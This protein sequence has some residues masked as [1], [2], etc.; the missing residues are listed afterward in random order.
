M[1]FAIPA[2]FDRFWQRS[3]WKKPRTSA[4]SFDRLEDRT[5][6]AGLLITKTIVGTS[7]TF[8]TETQVAVGETVGY[9][10]VLRVPE[11]STSGATLVET[12][13]AGLAMV[14]IDSVSASPT[15]TSSAPGGIFG[16]L[17]NAVISNAGSNP[18]DAGRIATFNLGNLTNSDANSGTEETITLYYTAVVINGGSNDRGDTRSSTATISGPGYS[19]SG[20]SPSVTIV[21]PTLQVEANAT[22]ANASPGDTVTFTVVIS[23]TANSNA[24]AYEV[25]VS[26]V[27]PT[28]VTYVATTL[29]HTSGLAPTT[30]TLAGSTI[31]A[32]FTTFA[33]D[34][35]STLSFQATVNSNVTPNQVITNTATASSTSLP[36]SV[37]VSQSF[38]NTL[39]TERTGNTSNPGGAENDY[40]ATGSAVV[41]ANSPPEVVSIT[42]VGPATT[43]TPTVDFTVTFSEAVT[44]VDLNDF[45]L[46][47][48]RLVGPFVASISG[49]GAVYTITVNTGS[50]GGSVRLDLV[51]DDS[52]LNGVLFRLGGIGAGNGS[53]SSG[54][55]YTINKNSAPT[56]TNKTVVVNEDTAYTLSAADFGFSDPFDTPAHVFQA[57]RITTPP[58]VGTLMNNGVEVTAG[59]FVLVSDLNANLLRFHPAPDGHGNSYA[60]FTFQ[61]QDNGGIVN[62]GL[63]L[64]AGNTFTVN[65]N[66]VNDPPT[67]T[68]SDPPAVDE[69]AG[70]QAVPNWVSLFSPGP[71][72]ESAQ[73]AMAYTVLNVSNPSLFATPITVSATGTLTYTLAANANGTTTFEVYVRD[74]GGTAGG[75]FDLSASRTF[76]LTVHSV[77]D[78]PTFVANNPPPVTEDA[79]EQTVASFATAFSPGPANELGQHL[80]SYL[81]SNISNPA[82][83]AVPPTVN[84]AGT[85]TYTLAP[86]ASGTVT[87]GVSVRDDGGTANHG[88]DTS[89]VRT[90]T[91]TVNPTPD[92]PSVTPATTRVGEQTTTGLVVHRNPADGTEVTHFRITNIRNGV[93]FLN[94]GTTQVVSGNFLTYAQVSAGLRFTPINRLS[95]P[96]TLF[97]FQVQASLSNTSAGLSGNLATAIITVRDTTA[98]DTI[99]DVVPGSVLTA[100][101]ASFAFHATDDVA[102]LNVRFERSLDGAAYVTTASPLNLTNLAEGSHTL[103][104]RAR[105]AA[106]NADATPA[107]YVWSV[108]LGAPRVTLTSDV[109]ALT[110]K[111]S[112]LFTIRFTE[113]VQGFLVS[114]LRI[115]GGRAGAFKAIDSRTYTVVVSPT[116]DG[117]M[118]V[119][120]PAG[121]ARDSANRNNHPAEATVTFDRTGPKTELGPPSKFSAALGPIYFTVKFTDTHFLASSFAAKD[122]L[123]DRTGTADANVYVVAGTGSTRTILL[124]RL[125]GQGRLRLRLK[126]NAARDT[127]GNL[128]TISAYS[129][130]ITVW[131]KSDPRVFQTPKALTTV[132]QGK[133]VV[134]TIAF[135][136]K[137]S[138]VSDG[139]YLHVQLPD[140]LAFNAAKSTKGWKIR[141]QF[142]RFFLGTLDPREDGSVR[143]AVTVSKNAKRGALLSLRVMIGDTIID[144]S[145][146]RPAVRLLRIA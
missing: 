122:V 3:T 54:Q 101:S 53:F 118:R 18:A 98:P 51:D 96:L 34:Q 1:R 79:T 28:G 63:D 52:I 131:G 71:A 37:V 126:A 85:L 48:S 17:A 76:T 103:R 89:T 74:N 20:T 68:A 83:F 55:T 133:V 5:V 4:L 109:A 66:A 99:F 92:T 59:Q 102:P 8:T 111:P 22:P 110:A 94:N 61:V 14:S 135:V 134:S 64:S 140:G 58:S 65:V 6:P 44:G 11:G 119:A 104:V 138:Q 33:T 146:T 41:T 116:V 128:A 36:G 90:V 86:D 141:G 91:L 82:F 107:Q 97:S 62:G 120:V 24:N 78:R 43:N 70:S 27:I 136:N 106:G 46:T 77:N 16:L 117:E 47:T 60:T 23:H 42:R 95:S 72:N 32:T 67:F 100:G 145:K 81:V 30:L 132:K 35:S 129:S 123:L 25:T 38:Y 115:T 56:G 125:V 88:I 57:V 49:S 45:T 143:F 69:D 75:G 40:R 12:L 73:N 50:G 15:L 80:L 29:H 7:Q 108:D 113:P 124:N 137:G 84:A 142:A 130:F 139:A 19:V 112:A 144:D 114:D 2:W 93:V 105:D 127:L 13:D 26:D 87:F 10:M 9:R 21:E 121:A 31:S 39:G